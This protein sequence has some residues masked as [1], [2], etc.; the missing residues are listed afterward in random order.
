VD[1]EDSVWVHRIVPRPFQA[2]DLPD[3]RR[4]PQ[5]IWGHSAPMLAEVAAIA[6]NRTVDCVY[7]PTWECEDAAELL[8]HRFPLVTGLEAAARSR[9]S[10]QH[11]QAANLLSRAAHYAGVPICRKAAELDLR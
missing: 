6:K 9:S 10:S 1:F 4:I 2:P 7:A 5:R 3:G 8:E 11:Q